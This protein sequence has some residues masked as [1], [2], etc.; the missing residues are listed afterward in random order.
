MPLLGSSSLNEDNAMRKQNSD[1]FL[2]LAPE[3]AAVP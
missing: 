1:G 2:V 3:F